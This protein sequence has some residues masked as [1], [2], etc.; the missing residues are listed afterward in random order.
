M[1]ENYTNKTVQNIDVNVDVNL[2]EMIK[3][4]NS[5]AYDFIIIYLFSVPPL[6]KLDF[7]SLSFD[8]MLNFHFY[9][10]LTNAF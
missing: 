4:V 2:I 6:Y 7:L 5:I 1:G 3:I 8:G 10:T 9:A